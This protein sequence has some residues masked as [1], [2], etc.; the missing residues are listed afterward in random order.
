[1]DSRALQSGVDR[2]HLDS[3]YAS[4]TLAVQRGVNVG[5]EGTR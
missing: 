3:H 2:R 4:E 5:V 1:M